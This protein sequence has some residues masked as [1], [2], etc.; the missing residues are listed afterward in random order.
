MRVESETNVRY[1][2][3]HFLQRPIETLIEQGCA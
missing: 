2:L 1:G 3:R